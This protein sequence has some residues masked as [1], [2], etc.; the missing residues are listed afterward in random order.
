MLHGQAVRS[1]F[2]GPSITGSRSGNIPGPDNTRTQ[3]Q[4][5]DFDR[6]SAV[7]SKIALRSTEH[8][9][10]LHAGYVFI[11]PPER[12]LRPIVYVLMQSLLH[13]HRIA[14]SAENDLTDAIASTI[15][16]SSAFCFALA[17][18]AGHSCHAALAFLG[19][20]CTLVDIRKLD[21]AISTALSVA[22]F[23]RSFTC[24]GL[25]YS[26]FD[27]P[28]FSRADINSNGAPAVAPDGRRTGARW[29]KGRVCAALTV[30]RVG[31]SRRNAS[32]ITRAGYAR[33]TLRPET[34]ACG[35]QEN[36]TKQTSDHDLTSPCP[37]GDCIFLT[38]AWP[39]LGWPLC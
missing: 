19:D 26:I 25:T 12:G 4:A 21:C 23:Q 5:H 33:S 27:H 6:S 31:L 10:E 35:E 22:T 38:S 7:L 14:T 29:R 1:V 36:G 20:S 32:G 16:D 28:R 34:L 18:I 17:G 11:V 8:E 24:G 15:L 39:L 2:C 3:S 37:V 9:S 13:P 30:G